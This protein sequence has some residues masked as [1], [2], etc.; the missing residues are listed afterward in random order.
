MS[1][2]AK[3][4]WTDNKEEDKTSIRRRRAQSVSSKN[5]GS[6]ISKCRGLRT[7]PFSLNRPPFCILT[8]HTYI[9]FA[10]IMSAVDLVL[11]CEKDKIRPDFVLISAFH[12]SVHGIHK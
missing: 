5:V 12:E 3:V 6:K 10:S 9:S 2:K 4:H 11:L 1:P 8:K 7:T